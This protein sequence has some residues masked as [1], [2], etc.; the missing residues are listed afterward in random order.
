MEHSI[1]STEKCS[2]NK[3]QYKKKKLTKSQE[4]NSF[5]GRSLRV[6]NSTSQNSYHNISELM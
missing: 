5:T 6:E 4:Y 3:F 2:N 1:V